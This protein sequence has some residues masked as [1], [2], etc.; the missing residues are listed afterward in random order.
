MV[1]KFY[2]VF[3]QNP[4]VGLLDVL[5]LVPVVFEPH[6]GLDFQ[7]TT[8]SFPGTRILPKIIPGCVQY[9]YVTPSLVGLGEWRRIGAFRAGRS[10][11]KS[12]LAIVPD[13]FTRSLVLDQQF[14]CE[15]YK[16]FLR[17][18][19]VLRTLERLSRITYNF[20]M[21]I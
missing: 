19:G 10:Q 1:K 4:L 16:E 6:V 9:I 2:V 14:K 5:D 11:T 8:R 17:E 18:A 12:K 3:E 13:I 20:D 21:Q 15:R 7:G